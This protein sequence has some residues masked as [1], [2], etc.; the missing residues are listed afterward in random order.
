MIGYYNYTV[1]LTYVGLLSSVFGMFLAMTGSTRAAVI[2]LLFSGVC[3]MFDGKI[4]RTKKDRT[5]DEKRFGIQIDSLCDVVCFGVFPAVLCISI[6]ATSILQVAI[7]ALFVLC[8]VI[9]L[10]YFNVTE[11]TRQDATDCKRSTYTGLPIT[12]SSLLVPL[13][14]CFSKLLGAYLPIAYS[15]LL[16]VMGVCFITP[17]NVKKP[18]TWGGI[19]MLCAGAVIFLVLVL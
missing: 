12:S 1:Y 6:G 14:M 3:D 4:A 7:A 19:V 9:R 13:L 16:I 15:A 5:K 17:L 11:E 2:C 8:G 10:A 18:G